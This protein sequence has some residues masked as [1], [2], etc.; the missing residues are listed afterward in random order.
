MQSYYA[1][2]P[3]GRVSITNTDRAAVSDL[4]VS[5]YQAG[6]MDSPTPSAS[7]PALAPGETWTPDL[8]ASFN[9]EV[10]KTEGVTP[11]TGEV[12]V[13]YRSRG[14]PVEQRQ[15]VTYDL[16]DR[17]A[18]T[19]DDD[20]KVGA[21]IT[22]ADSAL[23]NYASFARQTL[24]ADT[25]EQLNEPLQAAMQ[26]YAALEEIGLLY[27]ADP[28]SP[29]TQAQGNR[30]LVDSISLPR[31]TLKRATGDCDDLTV[32]F[33]SLL[34]TV[35]VETG[36]M[37]V[38]GHIYAAFNTKVPSRDY[39]ELHPDRSV[40]VNVDGELWVPIEITLIGKQGFLDA[41]RRGAELW[42]SYEQDAGKRGFN[43]TRVAQAVYRPV[44]LR[45][46]DL[47]LQYGSSQRIVASFRREIRRLGDAATAD[48]SAAAGAS[49]DKRDYNALGLAFVRYG[50]YGEAEQAFG[51]ALQIDAGYAS[52]RVDLGNIAFL[53]KNYRGA[54]ASYQGAVGLLERQ[55]KGTSPVAQRVLIN[56]SQAYH[57]LED[58]PGAQAS[59]A[60]A[61]SIDPE[62]VRD[63]AYLAQVGAGGSRA[64][65]VRTGVFFAPGEEE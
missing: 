28:T 52:A 3:I 29:F 53:Q 46:S 48:Y 31:D 9:Q 38:P 60:K 5:F 34:E 55:G 47:G 22:P 57:A 58:Y 49:G 30:Q 12:V 7:R 14:R 50:R 36:F 16:Q 17:T 54:L 32:L 64:S 4:E 27:Q 62:R 39:R 10:F 42:R 44:G 23:R 61:S 11:L 6:Y 35:G 65:E 63:F 37:T 21:F 24:K 18:I 56:I 25:I 1:R 40:T 15:P 43:R 8:L 51:R 2:N 41:W 13:R 26:L 19:W 59:F 45:E 33:S 20:R